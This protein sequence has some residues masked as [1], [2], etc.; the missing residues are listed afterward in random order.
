[1]ETLWK[2]VTFLLPAGMK[3][4]NHITKFS[5]IF[6]PEVFLN[7]YLRGDYRNWITFSERGVQSHYWY[8]HCRALHRSW[9]FTRCINHKSQR[10]SSLVCRT[11]LRKL[12]LLSLYSVSGSFRHALLLYFKELKENSLCL[13]LR[14]R[15]QYVYLISYYYRFLQP[16]HKCDMDLTDLLGELQPD[17]WP[18]AADKRPLRSSGTAL[19]IA[20]NLLE[21]SN[22]SIKK[23]LFS[24]FLYDMCCAIW[25]YLYNIKNVKN[26]HRGVLLL[27]DLQLLL[28]PN[29]ATHYIYSLD[30][31]DAR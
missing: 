27:V 1:M 30:C 17:P 31:V 15:F 12:N 7:K 22:N 28:L 20:V 25:Y 9:S 21:V 11:F 4:L 29:W 8:P 18:V 2:S 24:Y 3:W 10:F 13:T 26:T 19:S 14:E 16:V 23:N 5:F 6:Q